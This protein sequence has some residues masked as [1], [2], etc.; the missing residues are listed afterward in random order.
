MS[1][2]RRLVSVVGNVAV[3]ASYYNVVINPLIYILH[4]DFVRR[5]LISI[6]HRIAARLRNQQPP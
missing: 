6:A 2:I 1:S 4:Y 5:P 3:L